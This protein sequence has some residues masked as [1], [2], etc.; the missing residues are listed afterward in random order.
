M[1]A[2]SSPQ[3][4]AKM[5]REGGRDHLGLGSVSSGQ[6]LP[7]L[8]PGINVLT[9]HP[10]Y[11]S[12][13][14]FLVDEFW[15]RKRI[16]NSKEFKRFYRAREFIYSLGAHLCEKPEHSFMGNIVGSQKTAPLAAQRKESYQT[17]TNY[18][19]SD[20]GGYGLY[21]RSVII[22]MGFIYPGG[23][24]F[25]TPVDIATLEGQELAATFRETIKDTR[26]YRDYFENDLEEIPIDV[27]RE[28]I[29][30]A[31][32]CQLQLDDALDRPLLLNKF[33]R[34]GSPEK[35]ANRRATFRLFLDIANQTTTHSLDQNS[36]RQLIYFGKDQKG[37]A[38]VP[39]TSVIEATFR[40]WRMYQAREYYSFSL[41]TLWRSF[42]EWGILKQG[43]IR[44]VSLA[45]FWKQLDKSLNF[46]SLSSKKWL[47]LPKPDLNAD[48]PF[49][50]LLAWLEEIVGV[51]GPSENFDRACNLECPINEHNLYNLIKDSPVKLDSFIGGM[52]I[53]LSLIY[54][55][56]GYPA[57]RNTPEWFIAKLGSNNN[58]LDLDTFLLT[59]SQKINSWSVTIREIAH[60]IFTSYIILQHRNVATSK[61]PENTYRF[62]LEGSLLRFYRFDNSVEFTDSRFDALSATIHELGLFDNLP[63]PIHNLTPDGQRLLDLEEL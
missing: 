52:L 53:L 61:L 51:K 44:P 20:L 43:D 28:Y 50:D 4:I 36:F 63:N 29:D 1:T 60:W 32:L 23:R 40:R 22:E 49:S 57:C 9:I 10:R 30:K 14:T 26:Y 48:S 31:C 45:S 11:H 42:C 35:T 39:S 13:Y 8:S 17:D 33:L 2:N 58:R 15:R 7:E 46:N 41:N 62:R 38:F 27:I 3:W 19:K 16:G 47:N 12:F 25:E 54:L 18:I 56:F 59:L 21:Y 37:A 34:E 24:G 6:I 55:R 5:Y